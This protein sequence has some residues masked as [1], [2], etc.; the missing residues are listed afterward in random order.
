MT[1]VKQALWNGGIQRSVKPASKRNTPGLQK[2]EDLVSSAAKT[3]AITWSVTTQV[4]LAEHSECNKHHMFTACKCL[5][6]AMFATGAVCFG[7]CCSLRV[8]GA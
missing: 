3:R 4:F 1:Q 7:V 6:V 2:W 8:S 5:C